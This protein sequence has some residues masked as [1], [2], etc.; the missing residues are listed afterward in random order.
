[1]TCKSYF[2]EL[3]KKGFDYWFSAYYSALKMKSGPILDVG[4]GVGQVVNR[5]AAEG[6]FAVGVDVSPI[7]MKMASRQG[8]GS[9]VVASASSLPF[10]QYVFAS[11]GFHDFLEHTN[12]PVICLR[13]MIRVLRIHGRIVTSA[14]N[15][16][17]VVGLGQEYHRH[18]AGQR[19][20]FSNLLNL[21]RKFFLSFASPDLMQF[22]FMQPQL[23]P[24]GRGGDLDAVCITNPIDIRFHLRRLAVRITE[25][26]ALPGRPQ[27]IIE[28]VGRLPILRSV[29]SSSFIVGIKTSA[30]HDYRREHRS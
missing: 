29:S 11:T 13:E 12:S 30:T 1:M 15:F 26:S 2:S 5:L 10:R 9:F 23:D 7:G 19:Q 17:R 25:Q 4:C 27:G 21:V 16:L 6:F 8:R 22:E 3:H 24:E 14:P 20:K 28:K 18:M